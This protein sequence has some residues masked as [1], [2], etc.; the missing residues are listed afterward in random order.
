MV[1]G[2]YAGLA[3]VEAKCTDIDERKF[4]EQEKGLAKSIKLKDDQ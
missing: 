4:V 2:T 3:M 1:K